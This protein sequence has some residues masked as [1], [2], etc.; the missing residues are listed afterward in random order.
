MN[1]VKPLIIAHRG[2]SASAPENTL[3]AF[4]R[5]IEDGADGIELDVRLAK[6]GVPIVFHDPTLKRLAKIEARIADFTAEE[7]NDIDVGSWCN[8][9]YPA[10]ADEKFT[11]ETIPTFTQLLDFLCGYKNLIYV[12]LKGETDEIRHLTESVCNLV[13]QTDLLP[14][15]IVKSF[16][17][18]GVKLV[19]QILPEV[20][21]AALLEPTIFMILRKK[22]L[23]LEEAINCCADELSIHYSLATRKFVRCATEQNLPVTIWTAD[24]QAWVKRALTRGINAIITNNPALLLT[25]RRNL[26]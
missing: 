26:V 9:K 21:T 22:K 2:A 6:D 12:E 8:E 11:A 15:V 13:R 19:K 3:A 18:N 23:I 16:N 4:Q 20:R 5:A 14:N 25:E 7:L 1:A 24:N 10:K 17:L